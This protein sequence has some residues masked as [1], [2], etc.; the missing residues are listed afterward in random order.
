MSALW[1]VPVGVGAAALL[2]LYWLSRLVAA[3]L[4]S[5]RS[6]LA[7]LSEL[8]PAVV[9]LDADAAEVRRALENLRLR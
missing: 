2:P 1:W 7:V 4:E 5:L 3:E 6:S 9:A 8:R